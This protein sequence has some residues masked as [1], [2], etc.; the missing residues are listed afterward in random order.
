MANE[1]V[2]GR[3]DAGQKQD[4]PVVWVL[5]DERPGH[6]TQAIG[7]AE[8]LGWPYEVKDLRFNALNRLS[9]RWLGASRVSLD[10][11]RSAPLTPPWPDLVI[12]IGRRTVPL[13]RW[14]G[15]QSG[16][17]TRLV[18]LGRR[19][20]DFAEP[21]DLVVSCG[22]FRLPPHPRRL[23]IITPL[24]RVTAQQLAAAAAQWPSLFGAA[25]PPHIVLLVGGTTRRFRFDGDT[26]R[27]TAEA[28]QR[29]ADAAGGSVFAVTSRRTGPEATTALKQGLGASGH[30][31]EWQ[32]GRRENPYL[33]YL[34]QA[35]VIVV[36]GESESM[37]AEAVATGK[38]LYIYPIPERS[39]GSLIRRF[40]NWLLSRAK[41][42][43]EPTQRRGQLERFFGYLCALIFERG[44]LRPSRDLGELHKTLFEYGIARPFGEPLGITT[45]P[46][47]HETE[48]VVCRVRKLIG[49][50]KS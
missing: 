19:G 11:S 13:T 31:H 1:I 34:A 25:P 26:A 35:D 16:G 20:G 38:S 50:A 3:E 2:V 37:L 24:N 41:A 7:L 6:R 15:K 27:L 18:Q 43:T 10:R 12:G 8:A 47:L 49:Y 4:S 5:S 44:L 40:K 33:A 32:P 17:T 22:H 28:V 21:F 39:Q 29:F 42:H 36:T 23:E 14:I 46:A 45:R 9:N 30:V 48:K